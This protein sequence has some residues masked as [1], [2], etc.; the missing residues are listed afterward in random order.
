MDLQ[1][2]AI[3][4][5]AALTP[6]PAE[7]K[8]AEDTLT[9]FQ[10][11][12]QHLV[13]LLQIIVDGN[14]DLA[15]R[16]VASIH[17]KNFI[18]ENWSPHDP[19][20]Q[21]KILPSDKDLVRQNILVFVAQ[22]PA[23]LRAQLGE[24]LKTIIHADYPEQWPAL[25]QWVTHNLQDQQVY[26]ALFVLRI[27]SRK[28]EFKSDEERTPIH[29]VVEE[30]FP[31]LLNIF[32]R[33]VQIGNPSI[34]IAGLIKLICKIYW[35]SIY[36]EIP[37]KLYDPNVFDAW[38]VLFLNI[39]ERPVPLEGQ[40]TDPELR[41]SWGW[42]KVKKWTAHILNRLYTRFGD[43]K[44]Q[45]PESKAFAQ[46]FQKNYAAKILEC[47]LNL[48]NA[49]R[50]GG[51]LPE[52]VANLSL[53][54]LSNSLAKST[55]YSLLQTRLDV[56]LFE[57]IFPLMCF[58]DDDQ[59][60]WEED[61]HEYV[62]KGY[63]I[64]EDLYSSRTA[65]MDFVTELVRKRGK[66][67][68]QKFILF[69]VEIFKRYEQ[70]PI[71]I[72]P[73]RQ[74]DGALLAIGTL[75]DKLKQTE[76]YKSE[77]EP[78]LV[79]HVF[80][81]FTSPMGHI[82]AKAAWV[83]GQYA[84]INFSDPNNFRKALQSVVAGMRD[85]ELP[86]RVDSVFALRSFV[87]ACTDLGEIRPILPQLL[88]EF[89]KLMNEVENED[90]VFTLETIVDKFGEEMAPYAVGL[91]QNL[92]ATFWKCM[93]TEADDEADDPG[94]LAA[95]GC[96]RAISTILES[97]SKLPHLFAHVEPTLLPIMRRMLTT[98]GQEVFEEVLEI[99][100]Y[101]TFF[102]P[103]ISMDMW[104]LWPLLMEALA[105]W[106]I[107]FFS[108]ILVP[109]DNYISRST[110]HYLTCKEPDYQQSL[111]NMLSNIM[112]DKN[113]EDNDI[114]PAPKLI[115]VV[116]QNC[117]G[118]VDQWVEP[119]IRITVERLHRTERPF[120]KCLLMQVIADALYYNPSLTLNI[121]QKLGVATEIF[122]LW[123]QMLQQT[124]K[125]GVRVN[126]KRENDKKI[127]CLGLTSLLSLSA[128]QLPLEAL[129]RVFKATLDLLV[130]YKDQLTGFC[131]KFITT[132]EKEAPE[133]DDDDDDDD[134]ND[135]LQTDD[136][137]YDDDDEDG[138]EANS[139]RLQKLG[140]QE[141]VFRSTD[142]Y[143]DDSDDDFSDDE[144]LQSPIDDVDPFIL[145]VDTVKVMQ[146]SDPTRFQNLSQ[147]LD[148]R[149]QALANGVAQHAD[150]RRA[151][152]EKEKLEKASVAS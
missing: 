108:N 117:R 38:M 21:S 5:Q 90:L 110:V 104:S 128:D 150:Q 113:L 141:R 1:S 149:Y 86:V 3:V 37:K 13:R 132:A 10:Y 101:M 18:A 57:I 61:P 142:D 91:C 51:Y 139:S 8:A 6:N 30:T 75:C 152:I 129:E 82:R 97:V 95:V 68:L 55:T 96:L 20:E 7:R 137:D 112:N 143:D 62:R 40:P 9:K 50:V 80:P 31:H 32:S 14:C 106:A 60:L 144:D 102:S 131:Y 58:N 36:L 79:Q 72:K 27:L 44:L 151:V 74:K 94:A 136:D 41:K 67:N 83:A 124:K 123:F 78:M 109:L 125:N 24:C 146:A 107:D 70:A 28:Y 122:N 29:H 115:A 53:Q 16:Q 39:L 35:S 103:T 81:E 2:L 52:R 49:V 120:L 15:V 100:S 59:K 23:L 22:V 84:H 105:E 19:D 87:E 145:F 65:A 64:I 93:N 45:N 56:V 47:H 66:E 118:Q 147:T 88:D 26:A 148:F 11:T 127:C 48:L 99:A 119:Y 133:D 54:Y 85:P 42:W 33:L 43:L 89:F 17:F 76:P 46:H 63:D 114:D 92:A 73:Y 98:D 25:L 34:E 4:L 134:M 71:E 138:D 111:W 121:L 77:L 69:I 116:L 135:S 126:F 12:P 140:A 130:A